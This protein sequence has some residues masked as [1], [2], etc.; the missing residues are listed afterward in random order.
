M[1]KHHST[2]GSGSPMIPKERASMQWD[3]TGEEPLT[4]NHLLLLRNLWAC[5]SCFA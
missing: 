4:P 1:G 5:A 3:R 2:S